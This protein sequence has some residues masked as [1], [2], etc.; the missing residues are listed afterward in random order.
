MTA[1]RN[2]EDDTVVD[3]AMVEFIDRQSLASGL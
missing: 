2:I 3:I 1:V